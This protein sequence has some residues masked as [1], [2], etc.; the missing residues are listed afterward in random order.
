MV[1]NGTEPASEHEHSSSKKGWPLEKSK[2]P[3]ESHGG[4]SRQ[5]PTLLLFH[6]R[7]ERKRSFPTCRRC[8]ATLLDPRARAAMRRSGP[9]TRGEEGA[10]H[11]LLRHGTGCAADVHARAHRRRGHY[12]QSFGGV[13]CPILDTKGDSQA[14][15]IVKESSERERERRPRRGRVREFGVVLSGVRLGRFFLFFAKTSSGLFLLRPP[16]FPSSPRPLALLRDSE[17][18]VHKKNYC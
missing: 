4:G 5:E 10:A 11:L 7:I 2:L 16:C 15:E 3:I 17:T 1:S 8:R 14:R 6:V 13:L 12:S 18:R 9:S